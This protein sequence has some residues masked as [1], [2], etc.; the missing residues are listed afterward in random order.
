M[1]P[2]GGEIWKQGSRQIVRW[3]SHDLSPT[4]QVDL[5]LRRQQPFVA[6]Q[7]DYTLVVDAINDGLEEITLPDNLIGNLFWIE[8]NTSLGDNFINDWSDA[9]FSICDNTGKCLDL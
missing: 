2:N 4:S 5:T 3:E 8:V 6:S 7:K 1:S 9:P